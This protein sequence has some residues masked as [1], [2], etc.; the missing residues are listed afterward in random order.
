MKKTLGIILDSFTIQEVSRVIILDS[1]CSADLKVGDSIY[2]EFK[3]GKINTVK[4]LDTLLDDG[5][6]FDYNFPK[7]S[8]LKVENIGFPSEPLVG[9]KVFKSD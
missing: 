9:L 7:I 3:D 4:V 5:V 1:D 6:R 8:T 2:I